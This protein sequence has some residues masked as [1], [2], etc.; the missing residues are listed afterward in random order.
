[1]SE[2]TQANL[3]SQTVLV[4]ESTEATVIN[5]EDTSRRLALTIAQAAVDRK[6]G[7]TLVLRVE[8]VSY[9]AD[10]FVMGT[11]YSRVQVR[12]I[13]QAIKGSVEIELN[14]RPIRTEGETDGSWVLLDYGDTIVHIMMPREREFYNLEAFWGHAETV[15]FPIAQI[16]EDS[17]K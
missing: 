6:A 12:A 7:D 5:T 10:Y 11:G 13:A 9:L 2:Y 15:A 16:S 14:R 3:P 8:E 4:T 1:M 17:P